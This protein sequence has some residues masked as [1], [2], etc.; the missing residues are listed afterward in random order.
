M[1]CRRC[2]CSL[3]FICGIEAA[4][5]SD[6]WTPGGCPRWNHPEPRVGDP[7]P[8]WDGDVGSESPEDRAL[9]EALRQ[10]S[11]EMSRRIY[12][13]FSGQDEDFL[14]LQAGSSRWRNLAQLHKQIC[15]RYYAAPTAQADRFSL[16]KLNLE[17]EAMFSAACLT[18]T[19]HNDAVGTQDSDLRFLR[20]LYLTHH[21][22]KFRQIWNILLWR[23]WDQYGP[24]WEHFDLFEHL[25]KLALWAGVDSEKWQDS[26]N[27]L[28]FGSAT[29]ELFLNSLRHEYAHWSAD[30]DDNRPEA[31]NGRAVATL[32]QCLSSLVTTLRCC[33]GRHPSEL[34]VAER[35]NVK[36]LYEEL[37]DVYID[38]VVGNIGLENYR[39]SGDVS[40][41]IRTQG[42]FADFIT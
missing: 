22:A 9:H 29:V 11:V 16:F 41:F 6:H 28:A 30:T 17:S 25:R 37:L 19:M 13:H 23:H 4:E 32:A 15:Q 38:V 10:Q 1:I 7:R 36:Y 20:N 12:L 18:A 42:Q 14:A 33:E 34:L 3:C 8:M 21:A 35:M 40:S 24:E 27:G 31:I 5:D 26:G 2:D 39:E